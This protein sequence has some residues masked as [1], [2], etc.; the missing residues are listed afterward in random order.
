MLKGVFV[1]KSSVR[2]SKIHNTGNGVC[3]IFCWL[4]DFRI[5]TAANVILLFGKTFLKALSALYRYKVC[6]ISIKFISSTG[7]YFLAKLCYHSTFST[8]PFPLR[9]EVS[10]FHLFISL[11]FTI[12]V[13]PI[14]Q[15]CLHQNSGWDQLRLFYSVLSFLES[16][17]FHARFSGGK[18]NVS[19]SLRWVQ[20]SS[21]DCTKELAAVMHHKASRSKQRVVVPGYHG[22]NVA[23]LREFGTWR[24]RYV[25]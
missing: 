20:K 15:Q 4:H 19:E 13:I 12:N 5:G 8:L 11:F 16:A 25:L 10:I 2:I 6:E 22:S 17:K 7:D 23:V 18:Y 9:D 3:Y 24:I 21:D 1:I 14:C